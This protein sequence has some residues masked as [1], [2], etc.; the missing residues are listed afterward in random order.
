MPASRDVRRMCANCG[1]RLS[2]AGWICP[3]KPNRIRGDRRRCPAGR[4][5]V[6]CLRGRRDSRPG[7][8]Q[9][10]GR[11][12]RLQGFCQRPLRRSG[13]SH[14][15]LSPVS[16][17][18]IRQDFCRFAGLASGDQGRRPGR[19][20]GR[21]Y[22]GHRGGNRPSHRLHVRGRLRRRVGR[23][24]IVGR[25]IYGGRRGKLLR[26]LRRPAMRSRWPARRITSASATATPGP[27]TGGMGAYSARRR[28]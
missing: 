27:N 4:R 2:R 18:G 1:H 22:R 24:E 3:G 7:T 23:I 21:D 14:R 8:Q 19:G 9:G 5:V 11:A 12:G 15:R 25:G 26:P 28:C 16:R 17:G 13:H 20:Q 6:G 10:G